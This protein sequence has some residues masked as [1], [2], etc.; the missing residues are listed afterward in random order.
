[1]FSGDNYVLSVVRGNAGP[2]KT[3]VID[4]NVLLAGVPAELIGVWNERHIHR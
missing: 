4:T 1:M 3:V 2:V